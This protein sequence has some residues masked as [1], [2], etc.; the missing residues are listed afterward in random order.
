M[1]ALPLKLTAAKA[2]HDENGPLT[3][4]FVP[5]D[6]TNTTSLSSISTLNEAQGSTVTAYLDITL[7]SLA[8][9]VG[10]YLCRVFTFKKISFTAV[11]EFKLM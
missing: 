9:P 6:V 7:C 2:C 8:A 4:K 1:A 3:V 5:C 10:N 11:Q